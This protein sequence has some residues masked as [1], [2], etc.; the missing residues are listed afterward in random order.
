MIT[1]ADCPSGGIE[2]V[3]DVFNRVGDKWSLIV[4][5]TLDAGPQRFT[6]LRHS[7]P[8]ISQRMLT[9]TLRQ[10]ERDGLVSRTVYGEVPPRVEYAL[11]ELGET[12][13]PPVIAL[14]T[15]AFAHERE[16]VAH[17]D[18]YDAEN[19]AEEAG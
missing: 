6:A 9:L 13:V 16:I 8:G 3:R 2:I 14:A 19:F 17:R 4:I 18:R 5:R 15:W 11:T 7:I 1:D 12:I 10:L